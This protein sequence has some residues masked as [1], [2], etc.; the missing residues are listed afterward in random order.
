MRSVGV[1]LLDLDMTLVDSLQGMYLSVISVLPLYNREADTMSIEEFVE[2]YYTRD[3]A[4]HV[5]RDL[6]TRWRFWRDV[7]TRYVMDPTLYGRPYRCVHD[8][9]YRMRGSGTVLIVTG[10]EIGSGEVARELEFYGLQGLVHRVSAVGDMGPLYKK[11]D[12]FTEIAEY[13]E[14]RGLEKRDIVVISD[15]VSDIVNA[16]KIGMRGLGFVPEGIDIVEDM[17]RREGLDYIKTWCDQD[18]LKK[19]LG[20]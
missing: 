4:R 2:E 5:P 17:F 14:E 18:T 3:L 9:I 13:Y 20:I 10:R 15:V 12:L 11:T 1:F 6:L 8:A 19:T 16:E 7:W